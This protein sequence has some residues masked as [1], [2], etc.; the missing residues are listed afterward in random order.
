M[1]IRARIFSAIV[2][3]FLVACASGETE[4]PPPAS[5]AATAP[6]IPSSSTATLV[7]G[8]IDT[9]FLFFGET[10]ITIL[11]VDGGPPV[12]DHDGRVILAPG[13]H[14]IF[15]R[16]FRDPVAAYGCVIHTFEAGKIYV[17]QTTKPYMEKTTMWLED[18]ATGAVAGQKADAKM[19]KDPLMWG[20]A[21]KALFLDAPP[22]GC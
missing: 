22:T 20:P 9:G 16:A 4:A 6:D 17:V 15:V 2:P 7:V 21:L 12:G 3:L 1:N 13:A 8:H 19:V 18:Q 10:R 5:A 14:T 11:A